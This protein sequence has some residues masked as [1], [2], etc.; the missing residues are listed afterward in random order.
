MGTSSTPLW[1]QKIKVVGRLKSLFPQADSDELWNDVNALASS[2]DF[3]AKKALLLDIYEDTLSNPQL[4]NDLQH[5]RAAGYSLNHMMLYMAAP[6]TSPL[7]NQTTRAQY[8]DKWNADNDFVARASSQEI[9]ARGA[10]ALSSL[11]AIGG[12]V[13]VFGGVS[14]GF[15]TKNPFVVETFKLMSAPMGAVQDVVEAITNPNMATSLSSMVAIGGGLL[16]GYQLKDHIKKA[17]DIDLRPS[18]HTLPDADGSRDRLIMQVGALSK[19]MQH[20]VSHFS[21]EELSLFVSSNEDTQENMWRSNPP[22]FEQRCNSLFCEEGSWA[23]KWRTKLDM[24]C[25]QWDND[26]SSFRQ[27]INLKESL[28]KFRQ[29]IGAPSSEPRS[30]PSL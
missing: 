12:A 9:I 15:L 7:G 8:L 11:A 27:P 13:A 16:G 18:L 4:A 20:L 23:Q 6:E 24:T 30:A 2:P 28:A 5:M 14:F 3:D 26:T 21:P 10:F 1:A 17:Q 25:S 19:S 29:H 22:N